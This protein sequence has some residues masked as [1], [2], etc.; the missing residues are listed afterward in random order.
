MRALSGK[1]WSRRSVPRGRRRGAR[2]RLRGSGVVR[3]EARPIVKRAAAARRQLM[4]A[5][6]LDQ[7]GEDAILIVRRLDLLGRRHERR[8]ARRI[9]A[10]A[11]RPAAL[12]RDRSP[13]SSAATASNTASCTSR[14]A[15]PACSCASSVSTSADRSSDDGANRGEERLAHRRLDAEAPD[16]RRQHLTA[17]VVRLHRRRGREHG[18]LRLDAEPAALEH[19]GRARSRLS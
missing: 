12:R 13:T 17:I 18:L 4:W 16:V 7:R 5:L 3:D 2:Q 6:G 8:P 1:A 19:F 9:H 11:R 15:E 10:G 14:P